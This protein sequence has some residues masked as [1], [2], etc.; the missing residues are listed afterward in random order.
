MIEAAPFVIG[1]SFAIALA[2]LGETRHINVYAA[3]ARDTPPDAPLLEQSAP[4]GLDWHVESMP[5]ES[6]ATTWPP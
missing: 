3:R 2:V 5:Q 6:H 4:K 1:E